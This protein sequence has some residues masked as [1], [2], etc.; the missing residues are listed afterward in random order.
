VALILTK[1]EY[2]E[3]F[4]RMPVIPDAPVGSEGDVFKFDRYVGPLISIALLDGFTASAAG[5]K[6]LTAT[7]VPESAVPIF[8]EPDNCANLTRAPI[9]PIQ[10]KFIDVEGKLFDLIDAILYCPGINHLER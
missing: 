9:R 3:F 5:G 2:K 7:K 10:S 6:T 1:I 8:E 4:K